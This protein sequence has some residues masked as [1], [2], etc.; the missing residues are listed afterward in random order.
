MEVG[1]EG[2]ESSSP[3]HRYVRGRR[4]VEQ[5]PLTQ[6]IEPTNRCLG[7]GVV[8]GIGFLPA[9]QGFP[10]LDRQRQVGLERDNDKW[11]KNTLLIAKRLKL[12]SVNYCHHKV[13]LEQVLTYRQARKLYQS[14]TLRK[15]QKAL[16]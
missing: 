13:V 15:V 4:K 12:K 3:H 10:G 16:S 2:L 5:V 11:V 9:N 7:D 1:R 8:S 14:L 6:G